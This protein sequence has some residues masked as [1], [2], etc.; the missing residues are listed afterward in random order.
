MSEA[1][2]RE[3]AF[4]LGEKVALP[5][6]ARSL[7][8]RERRRNQRRFAVIMLGIYLG[9]CGVILVGLALDGGQASREMLP[10]VLLA[11]LAGAG[12][13]GLACWW[14]LRKHRDYRDPLLW[15]RVSDR[16]VSIDWNGHRVDLSYDQVAYQ[17]HYQSFRSN[18]DFLGIRLDTPLGPISIV[19]EWF[20]GGRKAAAAIV[21]EHDKWRLLRRRA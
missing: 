13:V 8:P 18:V 16:N 3:L 12:I 2:A 1:V 19:D 9:V 4:G 20:H 10:I 17:V 5:A 15:I 7:T 11:C 14:R 21:T 6:S